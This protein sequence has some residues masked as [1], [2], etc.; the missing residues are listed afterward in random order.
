MQGDEPVDVIETSSAEMPGGARAGASAVVWAADD[1]LTEQ[2]GLTAPQSKNGHHSQE[3]GA[4]SV[5]FSGPAPAEDPEA[6]EKNHQSP[7][8]TDLAS[9]QQ[10][11]GAAEDLMEHAESPEHDEMPRGHLSDTPSPGNDSSSSHPD[12]NH[13]PPDMSLR[14]NSVAEVLDSEFH[15]ADADVSAQA[16]EETS[17]D[18]I[19]TAAISGR[20]LHEPQSD[21]LPQAV[22]SE[23][24][25]LP[26]VSS[27]PS[28]ADGDEDGQIKPPEAAMEDMGALPDGGGGASAVLPAR[29]GDPSVDDGSATVPTDSSPAVSVPPDVLENTAPSVPLVDSKE[30]LTAPVPAIDLSVRE[31]QPAGGNDGISI[32]TRD[33]EGELPSGHEPQVPEAMPRAYPPAPDTDAAVAAAPVFEPPVAETGSALEVSRETDNIE[34][35]PVVPPPPSLADS[36]PTPPPPSDD[37][38]DDDKSMTLIEHLEE[39]RHRMTIGAISVVVGAIIG[40]FI[41]PHLVTYLEGAAIQDGARFFSQTVLG[42]FGLQIKLAFF[43]GLVLA[44]PVVLYQVWAFVAPGL[45]RKE[46]RYALPFSL[47]GGALFAAGAVTGVLIVPLAIRF[48]TSFFPVLNLEKL[49]DINSYIMFVAVIALIFGITFELP[50]FMVGFSLLGVVSSKFFIQRFKI[51]VF[52]IFG[53]SMIIT[54]GADLVSPTVLGTF[55]VI[56]YWLGVLLIRIIG[57]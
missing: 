12:T 35:P 36:S 39:L 43:T 17:A 32:T 56:L 27:A 37:E 38:S 3:S 6:L 50:I 21:G 22:D 1:L 55:L 24:A 51:A 20:P 25:A 19:A 46:R 41:V 40:W 18:A 15:P 26:A 49:L 48:L 10:G 2:R 52:I 57:R 9:V 44:S 5:A 54:P 53:T 4:P 14:G 31:D 11:Y 34:E 16:A 28:L 7:S 42:P 47:I 13:E 29:E 8:E 23:N 33:G 45:T 30:D